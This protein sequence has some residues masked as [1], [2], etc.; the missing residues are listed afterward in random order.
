M[1]PVA[2]SRVGTGE[3][4]EAGRRVRRVPT[5]CPRCPWVPRWSRRSAFL[6]S[7]TKEG[8]VHGVTTG[9]VTSRYCEMRIPGCDSQEYVAEKTKEQVS[10]VGGAVVTGVTA[11]AQKTVEG[12]GSIAAATGLV[13]KDQLAKQNEEGFLQ[14]GMVN[15]TGVPVDPENEAYEMPPEEEYQDYE[16]E[17]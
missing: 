17:A 7:R 3:G 5:A 6:G 9:L 15:N 11:V 10:N 13:K 14:E 2:R 4:G 1:H 16:P 12:A 8:V